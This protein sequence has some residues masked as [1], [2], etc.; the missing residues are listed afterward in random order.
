MALH[1]I[2]QLTQLATRALELAGA[3]EHA[4]RLTARALVASDTQGLASHGLSRAAQY[5]G[6]L[7]H[8]RVNGTAAPA[9][10]KRKGAA[11]LVDAQE[12]L[13]FLACDLAI[14]EATALAREF[15]I[16]IVAVTNSYHAGVLVDRLRAV[17]EA[18]LVGLGFANAPA[19]NTRSSAPTRS[20]PS[21]RGATT[22]R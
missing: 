14:T 2:E 15:G 8:G 6:H 5:A 3:S 22:C 20:R 21:S 13:A 7:R 9:V 16:S 19:A 10:T 18:G 1:T 12:G 17:A 11:A 4:A